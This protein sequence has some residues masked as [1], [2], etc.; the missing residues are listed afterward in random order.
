VEIKKIEKIAELL[1]N[2]GWGTHMKIVS[3][4]YSSRVKTCEEF[5]F[6][7][8]EAKKRFPDL[9]KAYYVLKRKVAKMRFLLKAV[10]RRENSR[11]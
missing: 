1:H 5:E 6:D 4:N 10:Y 11:K 8:F 7:I 9:G 2:R 3:G